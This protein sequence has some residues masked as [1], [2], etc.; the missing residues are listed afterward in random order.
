[1]LAEQIHLCRLGRFNIED[2]CGWGRGCAGRLSRFGVAV[3]EFL[4]LLKILFQRW[5]QV[6]LMEGGCWVEQREDDEILHVKGLSFHFRDTDL[7][8]QESLSGPVAE[9]ANEFGPN[10]LNLLHQEWLTGLHFVLLGVAVVRR[11]ALDHVCDVD[12]VA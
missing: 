6:A 3:E 12:V 1:M 7:A 11:S 2:R 8:L 9:G 10:Q 4:K 5:E